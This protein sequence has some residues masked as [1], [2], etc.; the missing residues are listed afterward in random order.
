MFPVLTLVALVVLLGTE[1]AGAR[2][3]GAV[4]KTAAS[5]GFVATGLA[6]GLWTEG[7][8]S[9]AILVGLV[10]GAVGDV[11]LIGRAKAPFL[12]GLVAFL[13]NHVAY[14]VAFLMLGA[15]L[16]VAGLALVPLAAIA[17]VVW[18]W[19]GHRTGSLAPA[20]MAYIAVISVM[21]AL[22]VGVGDPR[23]LVAALLFYASDL[24]VARERFVEH[25][26]VNRYVGLPLYYAGQLL[27][28]LG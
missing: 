15:D 9:R 13:A 11:F 5:I 2:V 4:A 1:R 12:A 6:A 19:M 17:A 28:A 20:V 8:A 27:F 18:R 21:V 16:R 24:C 7:P 10:L 3:P 23:L 22:A 14:V 26:P 25:A